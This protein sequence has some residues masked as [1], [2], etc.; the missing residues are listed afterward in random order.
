MKKLT[1]VNWRA[2]DPVISSGAL[3]RLSLMDGSVKTMEPDDW[4][5]YL[6]R[7]ELSPFVPTEV[8]ELFD[9]AR[10][11]MIYG[12]FFFPLFTLGLEQAF[13]VAE[14]ATKMKAEAVGISLLT[15]GSRPKAF[16]ALLDELHACGAL[17]A[18]DY[19]AWV[20]IRKLRNAG[21]H[22][23]QMTILTPGVAVA[24]LS[25]LAETINRLF[26]KP[27]SADQHHSA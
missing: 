23:E 20:G 11:A 7:P 16:A 3:V 25:S 4:A 18:A 27:T 10:G 8:R 17:S 9:V 22:A 12:L 26:D 6:L 15:R 21:T 1:K 5:E 2:L 14:A 24:Q 13:R 19:T